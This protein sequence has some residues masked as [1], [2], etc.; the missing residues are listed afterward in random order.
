M[1]GERDVA[2]SVGFFNNPKRF[3]VAITRAMALLVIV[4]HPDMLRGDRQWGN[5]VR[6]TPQLSLLM[7]LCGFVPSRSNRLTCYFL[8]GCKRLSALPS[9][10]RALQ[11]QKASACFNKNC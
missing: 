5:L 6:F 10:A 8:F 4:G 9:I 11:H 3:N 1:A 7:A 2:S